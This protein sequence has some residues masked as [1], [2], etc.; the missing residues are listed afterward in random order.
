V[1]VG[2][3]SSDLAERTSRPNRFPNPSFQIL[4]QLPKLHPHCRPRNVNDTT[5]SAIYRSGLPGPLVDGLEH[6]SMELED[7]G[8]VR[9]RVGFRYF[10]GALVRPLP[11]AR[12]R[13]REMW[14]ELCVPDNQA[15]LGV[16][17]LSLAALARHRRSPGPAYHRLDGLANLHLG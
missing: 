6:D 9:S 7:V 4:G 13:A 8:V 14:F 3:D 12:I 15:E 17:R 10:E 16:L 11:P 2:D 5:W 1:G